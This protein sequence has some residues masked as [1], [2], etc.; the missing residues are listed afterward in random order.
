[1]IRS[2]GIGITRQCVRQ[3]EFYGGDKLRRIAERRL[4]LPMLWN[5]R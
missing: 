1:M 3:T 4:E 5:G 2:V